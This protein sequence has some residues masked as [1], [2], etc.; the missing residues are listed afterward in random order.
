MIT[1]INPA[2]EGRWLLCHASPYICAFPLARIVET[3]RPLPVESFP[4]APAFVAGLSI[5]R[6]VPTPVINL[7]ALL[8]STGSAGT[9]FVTISIHGKSVALA[10]D[11]VI[12]IYRLGAAAT[13]LPPVLKGATHDAVSAVGMLDRDLLLF[14]ETTRV[15]SPEALEQLGLAA[16]PT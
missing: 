9:R 4:H 3:M 8:G 1:A 7:G 5:I 15:I 12:G 2:D 6:G 16:R 13:H 10:V 11:T 14:L